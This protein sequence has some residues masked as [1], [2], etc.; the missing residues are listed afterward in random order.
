MLSETD[1]TDAALKD[2]ATL[3]NLQILN[4]YH[5]RVTEAGIKTLQRQLPKCEI[6]NYLYY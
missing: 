3:K 4:I 6:V 2:L 1:V 5:T